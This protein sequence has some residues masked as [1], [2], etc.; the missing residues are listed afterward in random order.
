MKFLHYI[1]TFLICWISFSCSKKDNSSYIHISTQPVVLI[2][3]DDSGNLL[4]FI[5]LTDTTNI[6]S[7]VIRPSDGRKSVYITPLGTKLHKYIT[8]YDL[9]VS[10]EIAEGY[11]GRVSSEFTDGIVTFV[12]GNGVHTPSPLKPKALNEVDKMIES[13]ISTYPENFPVQLNQLVEQDAGPDR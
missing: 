9:C 12:G 7:V 11:L 5:S 4:G 3:H 13:G 10:S 1:L 2:S 6:S 8:E